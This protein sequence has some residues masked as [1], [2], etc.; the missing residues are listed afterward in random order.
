MRSGKKLHSLY[1][2]RPLSPDQPVIAGFFYFS[3]CIIKININQ[4][5]IVLEKHPIVN[6]IIP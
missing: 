6:L 5:Q 1:Y 2:N 4:V 3:L